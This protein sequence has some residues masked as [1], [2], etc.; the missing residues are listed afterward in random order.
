M[1]TFNNLEEM[2]PFY[3]KNT[4]TYEFVEN[5]ERLDVEFTFDLDVLASIIADNIIA[6]DIKALNIK[7]LNIKAVYISY[8][9]VCFAYYDI[10][11]KSIV[12]RHKNSKHFSLD[13]EIIIEGD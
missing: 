6:R 4:N 11:C 9:A 3:N 5:D 12:G 7:A 8:Y 2:K 10:E 1:K 13:G